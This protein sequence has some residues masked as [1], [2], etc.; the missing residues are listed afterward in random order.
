MKGVLKGAELDKVLCLGLLEA[1]ILDGSS[2]K[3]KISIPKNLEI[4]YEVSDMDVAESLIGLLSGSVVT[5]GVI[6]TGKC[7]KKK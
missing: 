4:E 1:G 3:L 6:I 2:C 5:D 7:D